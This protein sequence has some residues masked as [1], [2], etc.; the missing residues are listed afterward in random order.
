MPAELPAILINKSAKRKFAKEQVETAIRSIKSLGPLAGVSDRS[1]FEF[2][3]L[4][5]FIEAEVAAE[6]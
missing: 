6:K 2:A 4:A 1:L 3:T 5:R